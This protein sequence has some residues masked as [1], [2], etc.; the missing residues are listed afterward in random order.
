[1][2]LLRPRQS[3]CETDTTL[4]SWS[5]PGGK[6][7]L[8]LCQR[9]QFGCYPDTTLAS[10]SCP[11]GKQQLLLCRRHRFGCLLDPTLVVWNCR[12]VKQQSPPRRRHQ[13]PTHSKQSRLAIIRDTVSSQPLLALSRHEQLV[14]RHQ[15]PY[16]AI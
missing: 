14:L 2:P 8:L 12:G 13:S 15:H 5:C 16:L 1:M 6:Q 4:A 11:G 9:H 7:Q 3:G 10:W